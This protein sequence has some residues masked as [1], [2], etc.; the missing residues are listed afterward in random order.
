MPV[1]AFLEPVLTLVIGTIGGVRVTVGMVIAG[2]LV[3]EMI[4]KI[5]YRLR[6][7]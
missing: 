2:L 1:L 5:L 7:L 3:L 6:R 4:S